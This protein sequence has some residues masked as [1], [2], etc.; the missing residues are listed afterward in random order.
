[1]ILTLRFLSILSFF[2]LA[3]L[4]ACGERMNAEERAFAWW[5]WIHNPQLLTAEGQKEIAGQI[6]NETIDT[7]KTMGKGEFFNE[8]KATYRALRQ[9]GIEVQ[10]PRQVIIKP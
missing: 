1:L 3:G 6:P 10:H 9:R 5:M 7:I 2:A 8:F 4:D